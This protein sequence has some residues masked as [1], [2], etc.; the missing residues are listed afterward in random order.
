[1]MRKLDRYVMAKF[2]KT[3]GFSIIAFSLIFILVDMVENV[4][5]FLD[6]NVPLHIVGLYYVYFLPMIF[7]L[8][9]PVAFLLSSL[10]VVGK[11]SNTNELTVIK[12]SGVSL[13]RFMAPFLAFGLLASTGML[14]FDGFAVPE[15]N[16]LRVH[17]EREYM[18]KGVNQQNRYNLYFQDFNNSIV[19]LEYYE[20]G[21]ATA[22]RVS[23]Q[24]FDPRN[25][26]QLVQRWDAETMRWSAASERWTLLR[27]YHRRFAPG[28]ATGSEAVAGFDSLAMRPLLITPEIIEK[29]QRKP[30]E[31]QLAEFRDYIDRQRK[32]GSDIARLSVDYYGKI[33]F[34]FSSLIVIFFGVPFASVKR[35]SGLS[36]QFGVSLLICFVY[37]V[38][39]KLIQVFGYNGDISP[40]VAAWLPNVLFLL[41]GAIVVARVRK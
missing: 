25:P 30:E 27:G 7:S 38:F 10:F 31:M 24:E 4:D 37:L 17:I 20:E 1:M 33:A 29:M 13:Y 14:F 18:K 12:C 22:R 16:S 9:V 8:M 21:T 41:T 36:V 5:D 11:M 32:A 26:T 15:F 28:A 23:I 6:E 34:P 19:S 35:R 3:F 2:V 40:L 39:Q